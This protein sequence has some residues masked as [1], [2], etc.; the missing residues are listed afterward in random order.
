MFFLSGN[1]GGKVAA[2]RNL[3][4]A[5][6]AAAVPF[7]SLVPG[8]VDGSVDSFSVTLNGGAPPAGTVDF[9]NGSSPTYP[10]VTS[11]SYWGVTGVIGYG[12]V[13][14]N[15]NVDINH[16]YGQ[17]TYYYDY[18]VGEYYEYALYNLTNNLDL[19]ES[20]GSLYVKYTVDNS[21]GGLIGVYG[22]GLYSWDIAGLD[23]GGSGTITGVS[24]KSYTAGITYA[25]ALAALPTYG[26]TFLTG[27]DFTQLEVSGVA[28]TE[29]VV[30]EITVS[31]ATIV[32][33]PGTYALLG[34]MLAL[35]S[36]RKRTRLKPLV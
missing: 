25:S 28:V 10:A 22:A 21:I 16:E 18:Y 17:A 15:P 33:E 13:S 4:A 11:P 14:A 19:Y 29:M 30:F 32:P 34:T 5:S 36:F 20:S 2:K 23:W 3:I 35:A 1:K 27:F 9:S 7:V 6:L 12:P 8:S 31:E 26:S 24:L